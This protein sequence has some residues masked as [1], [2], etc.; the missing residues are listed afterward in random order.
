MSNTPLYETIFIARQDLAADDVDALTAKLSKI[1]TDG[2]G[3]V[4]SKEYWGLRTLSYKVKKNLRGHYVALNIDSSYEAV[5]ELKRVISF[6]E[7]IIRN[8]TYLV[9]EHE[10]K[11]LLFESKTAKDYKPKPVVKEKEVTRGRAP[12]KPIRKEGQSKLDL[13]L[14]QIQ[15][16]L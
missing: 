3:K 12:A 15:F 1:I 2:G 4:V 11:S 16:D 5:A 7:D 10:G 8:A 14:N 13:V 9:E 6:N